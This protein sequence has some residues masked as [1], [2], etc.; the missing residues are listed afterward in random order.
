MV[1]MPANMTPLECNAVP[2]VG[3]HRVSQL[4]MDKAN[5]HMIECRPERF[6]CEDESAFRQVSFCIWLEREPS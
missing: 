6:V 1:H 4:K 2:K 3:S 5:L